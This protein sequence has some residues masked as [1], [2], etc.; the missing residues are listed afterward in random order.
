MVLHLDRVGSDH[1]PLLL[2]A[3]NTMRVKGNRPFRFIAAWQDHHQFKNFLS[4]VWNNE[5]D[6]LNNI[7]SFQIKAIDWNLKVFGH[8]GRKKRELLARLRGIER[9]LTSRYSRRLVDLQYMLKNELEDVLQQEERG[10]FDNQLNRTLLVLIPKIKSPESFSH[11][12]PISL[13]SVLYKLIIKII[14]NRRNPLLSHW[15][16]ETQTSFVH[17]RSIT[18]NIIIAQEV[19]HSMR[20]KKGKIGYMAI[21]IDLEK[22]YDRLEWTFIDD[23]LKELRIPDKLRMLI[24]RCVSS[25]STQVLWNGV[26]SASF[27]PSR[28]FHQGDPLSPYLFVMCMERLGH[29]ITGAVNNG[30]WKPIRLCRNVHALSHLFFAD[31]L[32]LLAEASIEQC[33]VIRGILELFYNSSGQKINMQK[34]T[35]Y[36]LKNV[37]LD[38]K[39][40][41]SASFGFQEVRNLSK[42]LGVP[43]LHSRI[44]KASYSYIVSRVRDKLTEWKEKSLSLARRIT[45]AKAELSVIHSYSIQSMM[46]PKGNEAFLMKLAYKLVV[47]SDQLWARV[48][49]SKYKWVEL[50]PESINRMRSS[51]VWKGISQVWNDVRQSFVWNIGNGCNVDFWREDWLCELGPLVSFIVNIAGRDNLLRQSVSS[52][53]DHNGQWRWEF[54][55][56]KLSITIIQH[57]AATMPPRQSC[58]MD[59]L[60]WKLSVDRNFSVKSTYEFRRGILNDVTH[61]VWESEYDDIW[62]QLAIVEFVDRRENHETIFF[63]NMLG[64]R[65]LT[66]G[67]RLIPMGPLTYEADLHHVEVFFD[68]QIVVGCVSHAWNLGERLIMVETDSLVAIRMLKK[69]TKRGSIFTLIDCVNELINRDWNIVLKHIS[70]NANKVADRL[71]KIVATRGEARIVFSTPPLKV[72]DIVQREAEDYTLTAG[73]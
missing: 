55:V 61:K 10:D 20:L 62:T 32:V 66:I 26:M 67:V 35:I 52:M 6:V 59:V 63:A 12:R 1:C 50:I 36:Y 27:N 69:N 25:V 46:L 9:V 28:G 49:R 23:T 70:R 47:N 29:T 21:K 31:D 48:L 15:I 53:V 68:L 58:G 45:L 2:K 65:L 4:E 33:N 19:V 17:D 44:T 38:L 40:S 43:L 64:N 39:N 34:T 72:I 57:L 16:S 11:F 3:Q 8:V 24:M 13:C 51:H 30:R 22:E 73:G 54:I 41:I 60:G 42:Y 56:D 71:A 18:D 14:V 37:D 7:N 5:L